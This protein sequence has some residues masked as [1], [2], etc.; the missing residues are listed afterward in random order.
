MKRYIVGIYPRSPRLIEATR[1]NDPKLPKLLKEE[2]DRY[3]KFM[4]SRLTYIADPM[5]EWDDIFRPFMN[6]KGISVGALNRFF[7]TNNFYR[8][9]VVNNELKG[10]GSIIADRISI[11]KNRTAVSIADP[12]TFAELNENQFYKSYDEYLLAISKM[13][14]KEARRLSENGVALIQLDAPAIAYNADRLDADRLSLIRDAI[15]SVK[16]KVTAKVYL[17][18]YFGSIS[19]IFDRLLDI[20]IDGLSIDLINNKMEEI[21]GYDM[22][23]KGLTLGVIDAM[24]TKMED[25]KIAKGIEK[26]L[27]KMNPKDAYLST[28]T[29]LEFL[30]YEFALKKIKRL[31]EIAKRVKYDGE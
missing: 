26:M 8:R 25:L 29:A 17:H 12:Y 10:Y 2:R 22:R 23:N 11:F 13:L 7:E 20:K 3:I 6:V 30:P 5:L 18:L 31:E 9:L 15:E 21:I 14:N 27:D 1:V 24:N 28:N 4:K 16:R 19:K